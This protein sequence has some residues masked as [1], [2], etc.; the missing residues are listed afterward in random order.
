MS[1][2]NHLL[3]E[4]LKTLKG[5]SLVLDYVETDKMFI[6]TGKDENGRVYNLSEIEK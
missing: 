4:N 5:E 1:I 3:I 6:L 2:G